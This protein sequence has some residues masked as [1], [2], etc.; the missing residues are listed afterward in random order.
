MPLVIQEEEPLAHH[1][2]FRIGGPAHL[3]VVADG[4]DDFV[5]ALQAVRSSGMPWMVLG[6]GSNVLVSDR[7]FPGIVVHPVGGAVSASGNRL[8]V[9]AG[10]TMG[11]AVAESLASGLRG[12][13][14]AIGVP[15]TVG[16][17]VRGNAGC[18]GGDMAGVV[19]AVTVFNAATGGIEE[20]S[21]DAAEFGYRDS[22]FKRCPELVILSAT[23]GLQAGDPIEG[24]R[25]VREFTAR[26]SGTQD[27]GSRNAGCV[28]KNIPWGRRD[29]SR[30]LISVH[31]P[32]LPPSGTVDGLSAGFVIDQAGLKGCQIGGVR[33]SPLH[34]NFFLN[35]GGA[36]AEDVVMLAGLAKERI[37]RRYGLLLEEEIQLVGF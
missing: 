30:E 26:R 10:V 35:I 15:G 37:H 7:G 25:L 1:T 28:F 31:F 33:I 3:F 22:I 23:L 24:Q 8:R 2:A 34:G 17:S 9:D 29:I 14:W 5:S 32:E 21:A 12:F 27:I 11:M 20:W 36:S 16:G 4:R 13:E 6:S 19:R 18:F